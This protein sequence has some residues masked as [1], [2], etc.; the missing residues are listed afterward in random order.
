MELL[1]SDAYSLLDGATSAYADNGIKITFFN[2]S[3]DSRH[4]IFTKIRYADIFQ[5]ILADVDL[6][7]FVC[8]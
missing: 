4:W 1:V 2:Y 7:P 8:K 5:L 3:K 6:F